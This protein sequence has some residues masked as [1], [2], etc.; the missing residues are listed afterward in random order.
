MGRFDEP[1]EL[2]PVREDDDVPGLRDHPQ[3]RVRQQ[4]VEPAGHGHGDDGV[5][6]AVDEINVL[7]HLRHLEGRRYCLGCGAAVA[8]WR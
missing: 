5:G 4:L 1:D 8:A 6:R 2:L 3:V 7:R